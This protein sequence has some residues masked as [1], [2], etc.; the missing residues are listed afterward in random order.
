[1]SRKTRKLIWSVP[2]VAVFAV[3][4]ALAL[5]VA[6]SPG[7]LFADDTLG[8]PNLMQPEAEGP[9]SIKLTWTA[10]VGESPMGYRIDVSHDDQSPRVV[11]AG[12]QLTP[13]RTY[14]HTLEEK[15]SEHLNR[16]LSRS[17]RRGTTGSSPSTRHGVGDESD[18][19]RG[20]TKGVT[21]PE[22]VE[23]VTASGHRAQFRHGFVGGS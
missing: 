8:K 10:P 23:T 14:V 1:M 12:I 19:K 22:P 15:R 3:V 9:R 17:Q 6:L 11:R 5:F 21:V 18:I 16:H 7:S 4:G 20:D 13:A 2:L